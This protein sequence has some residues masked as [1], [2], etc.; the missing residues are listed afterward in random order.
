MARNILRLIG[1]CLVSVGL[2]LPDPARLHH[3]SR[4]REPCSLSRRMKSASQGSSTISTRPR[5]LVFGKSDA[6]ILYSHTARDVA[7][8]TPW[9]SGAIGDP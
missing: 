4:D 5:F 8:T 7:G 1:A 9:T 3:S 6:P 2:S